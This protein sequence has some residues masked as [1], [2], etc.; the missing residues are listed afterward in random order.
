MSITINVTQAIGGSFTA[1]GVTTDSINL[2]VGGGIGPVGANAALLGGTGIDVTYANGNATL[3]INATLATLSDVSATA[4][5][6]GQVLAW[7]GTTWAAADDSANPT[8]YATESYVDSAVANLVDSSPAALDTLNELAAALG[9]DPNFSATITASL[10]GKAAA[11]HTHEIANITGLQ[12]ALDAKAASASLAT[13]ASSGNYTDLSGTPTL[14]TAAA[15]A[16]TDYATAAQGSLAESAVQPAD[17]ANVATSGNYSDLSGIPSEF[18]PAAHTHVRANITDLT[19]SDLDMGGNRVLFANYYATQAD[20]PSA[21]TYHGMVAHSHADGAFYGAHAGAW[22]RLANYGDIPAA[23]TVNS[24]SG[25]LTLAAGDNVTI[26]TSGSTLTVSASGSGGGVSGVT[27]LDAG[28]FPRTGSLLT[29]TGDTLTSEA[30][31]QITPEQVSS[32]AVLQVLRS[33]VAAEVPPSLAD[34]ELAINTQDAK[35]FYADSGGTVQSFELADYAAATHTHTAAAIT[36]F[37]SAAAAAAPL[38]SVNGITGTLTLAAGTGVTITESGS[39]ITF[40]ASGVSALD[41]LTDVD[42]PTP[43]SGQ[44]LKW[45][46]TAWAPAT[47]QFGNGTGGGGGY[48]TAL[49]FG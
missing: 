10:A 12:A 6:A 25:D 17:L 26:T 20:F 41:D 39:T 40:S 44:V 15:T 18:T 30:G 9:N 28:T 46:G 11:N 42:A 43:S 4:P 38:Q 22:V 5:T 47:D 35:L 49:L 19:T 48:S 37:S 14:G 13:V 7:N 36:D 1:A 29:E 34:G 2:T 31:D 21:T 45:N 32:G 24:L 3:D 23:T 16:A 27:S 33:S 8:G